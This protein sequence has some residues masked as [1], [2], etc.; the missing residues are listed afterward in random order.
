MDRCSEDHVPTY[1]IIYRGAK[2]SAYK[3]EWL[4]CE[5]CHEKRI[6]GTPD[7]IVSLEKIN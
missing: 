4:V 6:F 1:K 2:N 3:P 7:D 5:N